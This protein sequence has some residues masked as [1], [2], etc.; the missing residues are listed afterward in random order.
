MIRLGLL[1]YGAIARAHATALQLIAGERTDVEVRLAAVGGPDPS[2]AR[3]FAAEFAITTAGLAEDV[4]SDQ[5]IDA[6]IVASPSPYHAAQSAAALRAGKHVLCEIPLALSLSDVDRLITVADSARR[7]LMVCHTFRFQPAILK[8][9][10]AVE[11]GVLQPHAVFARFL[12]LRRNNTGGSGRPRSWTDNLL[13]HHGCH[14]VDTA[15]WLLGGTA[16]AVVAQA[17]RPG[18]LG[19]EMDI[20]LSVLTRE[21]ALASAAL[22][23]NS[24][25]TVV[26]FVLVGDERTVVVDL[27]MLIRQADIASARGA[28]PIV[29][30][31]SEFIDAIVAGREPSVSARRIRSTMAILQAAHDQITAAEAQHPATP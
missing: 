25:E 19:I 1:G 23:Y 15:L 10:R 26:D 27:D 11:T 13:W 14:V 22:S 31:V 29:L 20:S 8:A 4:I 30:E 12:L 7:A 28:H 21:G 9:R 3:E 18:R 6:V 5:R 16:G 17:A 24:H 2:K